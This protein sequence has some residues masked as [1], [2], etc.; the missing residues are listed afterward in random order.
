M[1]FIRC[2]AFNAYAFALPDKAI[3]MKPWVF[4]GQNGS[5]FDVV[6]VCQFIKEAYWYV[7]FSALVSPVLFDRYF[8][9]LCKL[10]NSNACDMRNLRFADDLLYLIRHAP[11]LLKLTTILECINISTKQCNN[12]ERNRT[13]AYESKKRKKN[14]RICVWGQFFIS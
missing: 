11:H 13:N 12:K 8:K 10:L 7:D 6:L 5:Q 1:V 9:F 4:A 3:C 14:E 2:P